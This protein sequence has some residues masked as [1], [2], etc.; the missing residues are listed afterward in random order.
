MFVEI[1]HHEGHFNFFD[2]VLPQ[3]LEEDFRSVVGKF[4]G[5]L[6]CIHSRVKEQFAIK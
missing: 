4:D 6:Q 2:R 5:P 1:L 3:E